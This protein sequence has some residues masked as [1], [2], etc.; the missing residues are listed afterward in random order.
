MVAGGGVI[1]RQ[2]RLMRAFEAAVAEQVPGWTVT[3]LATPP[4]FGAIRLAES[5]VRGDLPPQ[6]PR[7]D[8]DRRMR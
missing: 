8:G 3:L 5:L 4:A 2:P 1:A 7:S 6:L